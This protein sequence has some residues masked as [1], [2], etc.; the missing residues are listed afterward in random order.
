MRGAGRIW[1]DGVLHVPSPN[2]DERPPGTEVSLLVIHNISLPPGEFGGGHVHALFTNRLDPQAHPY[3]AA[4]A[5]LEVSAHLLIARDGQVTQFVALERRAW[6]AGQSSFCGRERCND[7]SI[8]IELEGTDDQPFNPIQYQRLVE[9][10][11]RIQTHF[12][13]IGSD[14]IVGHSDIAPGRKTDPGP[15]FHWDHYR[16]LL[17]AADTT[18]PTA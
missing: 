17:A 12:P 3:F 4:I 16:T 18:V 8:G 7:F 6:H 2:A 10:T 14:S 13:G 11:G 15:Y 9:L 1:L 5:G